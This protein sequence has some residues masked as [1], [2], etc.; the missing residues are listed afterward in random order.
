M[1]KKE[2]YFS[3]L[4]IEP[5]NSCNLNC[6]VCPSGNGVDKRPKGEMS[7][8]QFKKIIKPNLVFLKSVNLWGYGEPF[9]A[10]DFS[11]MVEYL[12]NHNIFVVIYTNGHFLN[13]DF[14]SLIKKNP[15][16]LISFSIDGL[17]Q[18]IYS[19]YRVGGNL[20]KV[21]DN[22]KKLVSFKKENNLNN[23]QI[24]WQFLINKKNECDIGNA[25][26]F[27]EKMGV[28]ILKFKTISV[29]KG[30]LLCD[31]FLPKS[32]KY[33]REK[34]KIVKDRMCNF[35]SPGMIN[36][37]W[38]GDIWPCCQYGARKYLMGN[39]FEDNLIDIWNSEKYKKFKDD[40][41]KEKNTL[42]NNS[43]RF[44]KKSLIYAKKTSF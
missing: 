44:T 1:I 7:F 30:D 33:Q 9:L 35:I 15:K 37:C 3:E 22:L 8:M 24:V 16:M 4:M 20:K 21:L 6:P 18:N 10:K 5:T 41:R 39:A 19:K 27:V 25:K 14:L 42:C 34:N 31:E 13:K 28:D 38:N 43:C 11:K 36:I 2:R 17:T 12:I 29:R 23:L 26:D 40:Y 32:K